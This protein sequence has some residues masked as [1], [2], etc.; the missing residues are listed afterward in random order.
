MRYYCIKQHDKTGFEKAHKAEWSI[1][2]KFELYQKLLLVS[3]LMC[4]I[5]TVCRVAMFFTECVIFDI[6]CWTAIIFTVISLGYTFVVLKRKG[7]VS[8]SKFNFREIP[9]SVKVL[10]IVVI[11]LVVIEIVIIGNFIFCFLGRN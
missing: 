4:L 10:M 3:G 1:M 2:K 8:K 7:D 9:S 6:I 5:S 11:L